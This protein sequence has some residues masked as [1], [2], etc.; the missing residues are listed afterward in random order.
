MSWTPGRRTWTGRA[1][2]WTWRRPGPGRCTRKIFIVSTPTLAGRSAIEREFLAGTMKYFHVACPHCG[3]SY[4]R[5]V[6]S[7]MQWVDNDPQTARY[8]CEHCGGHIQEHH[9][10]KM[11][12]SGQWIATNPDH[13]GTESYHISTLYSPLGWFSW[14]ECVCRVICAQKR[15]KTR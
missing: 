14:A 3:V 13:N 11:L 6:W 1:A 2:P 5:L 7:Q 15:T 8:A 9:K 4:Q 12:A 10:T